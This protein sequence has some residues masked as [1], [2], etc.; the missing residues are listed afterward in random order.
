MLFKSKPLY[1]ILDMAAGRQVHFIPFRYRILLFFLVN[2]IG[3]PAV[4]AKRPVNG[5]MQIRIQVQ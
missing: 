5:M 3:L 1:H 2:H 4:E